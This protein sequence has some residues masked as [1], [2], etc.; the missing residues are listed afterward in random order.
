MSPCVVLVPEVEVVASVATDRGAAFDGLRTRATRS[1]DWE[2]ALTLRW[3]RPDTAYE[4]D[5]TLRIAR[6]RLAVARVAGA[7][8]ETRER[9]LPSDRTLAEQVHAALD[10]AEID[11][12]LAALDPDADAG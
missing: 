3:H 8:W 10:R 2:V 4:E 11:A 12:R 5:P 1:L 9:V 6:H 7:L